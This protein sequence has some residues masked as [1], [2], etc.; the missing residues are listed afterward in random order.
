MHTHTHTHTHIHLAIHLESPCY[1]S[2]TNTTLSINYI[3]ILKIK[4]QAKK[5]TS[6]RAS[7][8]AQQYRICLQSRRHGFYPWVR[9]I[10]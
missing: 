1:T 5:Y 8:V 3:S 10:P 6:I 2:E 4:E 7:P 9:K